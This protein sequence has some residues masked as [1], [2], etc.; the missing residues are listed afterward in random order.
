MHKH[1]FA[2]I[3]TLLRTPLRELTALPLSGLIDGHEAGGLSQTPFWKNLTK[4]LDTMQ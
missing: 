3:W 1:A 2:K 4:G